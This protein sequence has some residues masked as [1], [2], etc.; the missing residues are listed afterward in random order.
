MRKAQL[1][2]QIIIYIFG[3]LVVSLV[4]IYG[5]GAVKRFVSQSEEVAFIQF[6]TDIKGV[7]YSVASD[8]GSVK[9][10]QMDV[11]PD[12]KEVCFVDLSES[13]LNINNL[14]NNYPLLYDSWL[15]QHDDNH[16]HTN[17]F[18]I[19]KGGVA[20][21]FIFAGDDNTGKSYVEV[22]EPSNYDCIPAT[23]G[24]IRIRLEGKGDR[25]VVSGWT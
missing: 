14:R 4:L 19:G 13:P 7:M 9:R 1:Q 21:H 10:K 5:Y 3:I 15:Q 18:L 2:G 24:K 16:F 25:A 20:E 22:P 17:I 11:P 8:Y 23:S 6:K 12:I